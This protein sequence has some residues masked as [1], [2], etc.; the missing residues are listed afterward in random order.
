MKSGPLES[1]TI[2]GRRFSVAEDDTTNLNLGGKNN[3]VYANGDGTVRVQQSRVPSS[4]EGINIIFDPDKDDDGYLTE[5]KESGDLVDV[6]ITANDGTIFSGSAQIT[7]DLV[8]DLTAGKLPIT[9]KGAM[10]KQG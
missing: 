1:I 8:F 5:I 7:G 6:S 3:E 10:Q 9:L 4:V 2:K